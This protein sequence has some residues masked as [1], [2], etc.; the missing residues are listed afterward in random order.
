MS[1]IDIS[2]SDSSKSINSDEKPPPQI[3]EKTI[4]DDVSE[5]EQ[6]SDDFSLDLFRKNRILIFVV[7][8][9]IIIIVVLSNLFTNS[10]DF[11]PSPTKPATT[12]AGIPVAV[13]TTIFV[14][15]GTTDDP[16]KGLGIQPPE[17][18]STPIPYG[19]ETVQNQSPVANDQTY[20]SQSTL[21][22]AQ[23]RVN[24]LMAQ[25]ISAVVHCINQYETLSGIALQYWP[26]SLVTT[27]LI[28]QIAEE[29]GIADPN[30]I[31]MTDAIAVRL[32]NQAEGVSSN[33]A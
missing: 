13:G 9:I 33:G 18:T 25:G 30:W 12:T 32:P 16:Q 7:L 3:K 5:S 22:D 23:S 28:D 19:L 20:C 26:A 14:P 31:I 17:T 4:A 11:F 24:S 8:A 29:N 27:T 6:P 1:E 2:E 10:S 21:Q 15:E